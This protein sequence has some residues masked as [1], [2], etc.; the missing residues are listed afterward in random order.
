LALAAL[1][2]TAAGC[3][4]GGGT[5]TVTTTHV[6]T[7]TT[8]RTVTHQS[9]AASPCTGSQLS[10]SFALVSGSQGAGQV[11][12]LL[13][14]KNAS[15]SRCYVFGLPQAQLI[16]ANGAVLPTHIAAAQAAS[17]GK[18]V[19]L[20]PGASAVAQARFSSSVPGPGDAQSGSCQ[21]QASTLRVTP[22]GGGTVDAPIQP[23]TSV[24]ERG[25][26]YFDLLAAAP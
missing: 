18:P 2:L 7:V 8:T 17:G 15:Q 14:L 10:G 23:P 26:L 6:R 11:S 12:Y 16:A 24:C 9:A 22:D 25:T 19:T 21:P 3:G 4:F 5:K 1:A 13:T 20:A